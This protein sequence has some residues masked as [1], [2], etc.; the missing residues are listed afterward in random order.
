MKDRTKSIA[1][2]RAAAVI[3][4]VIGLLALTLAPA[5]QP[6]SIAPNLA[7]LD[8]TLG[9]LDGP[10]FALAYDE[11]TGTLA[12]ACEG[13]SIHYWD[14]G[15]VSGVRGGSGTPNVL[16]EHGGPVTALAWSSGPVL[17]SA[18]A[19][20][21]ILFWHMPDGQIVKSLTTDNVV[22]A[23]AMSPDGK[24]LA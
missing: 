15:V 1:A 13:R 7:R 2:V 14:K 11:S 6:P 21:K 18:G 17:V 23:L 22:R 10:G 12:A 20:K 4:A 16:K 5:Q 8:Q 19:D 9:G 3:P 24:T